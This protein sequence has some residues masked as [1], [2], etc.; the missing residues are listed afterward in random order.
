MEDKV[1]TYTVHPFS[2]NRKNII[3]VSREGHRKLGIDTLLEIDVTDARRRARAAKAAGKDVSFTGWIVKCVAQAVSE[4]KE[5][6]SYRHG[7]S[8]TLVFDDVDVPI[9][10][11]RTIGGETRPAAYI[12]RKANEKTLEQ[13]TAEIRTVQHIP[14]SEGTQ[15]L[16]TTL[17]TFERVVLNAPIW[18]KQL[19]ITIFRNN[20]L[21]KKKHFGT[22]AVTAIGMKGRFPG[23]VIGMGGPVTT[24]FAVGGITTKPGIVNGAVV[25]REFLHLQLS[26]DHA[27]VDGGPLARFVDRLTHLLEGAEF[28]PKDGQ[29]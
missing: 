19:V 16:G 13:I 20:A 4:H 14:T 17:T 18:M 27:L 23:W 1:G 2:V 22:V 24:L 3:L 29:A 10:V 8:K 21:M 11:E 12:I 28:L 9:P 7:R 26:V 15:L 6:N 5:F 25:P